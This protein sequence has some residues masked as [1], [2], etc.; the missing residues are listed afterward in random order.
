[1]KLHQIV[2]QGLVLFAFSGKNG[3][4]RMGVEV[5]LAEDV[6]EEEA[7]PLGDDLEGEEASPLDDGLE[8][9]EASPL[10]DD[11]EA[12]EASS[13][14]DDL[15][16]EEASSSDN[17]L[18]AEEALLEE[19]MVE[20]VKARGEYVP[21]EEAEDFSFQAEVS[22]MLD[23]VVNSLYQNKDVFLRELLSNAI[24]AQDKFKHMSLTDPEKYPNE[25]EMEIGIEHDDVLGTVTISDKGLGMTKDE[26][27]Q[28]LGTVAQSGTTK[29]LEAMRQS[30]DVADIA[31]I[32]QFGVGFYSAFLVAD[33]I[34]VASKSPSSD[35]QMIWES[36]NGASSFHVYP[37][38]RGNTLERGTEITLYLK[39]DALEYASQTRLVE[40][41]KRYSEFNHHH[42]WVNQKEYIGKDGDIPSH[43]RHIITNKQAMWTQDKDT[44]VDADYQRFW[45]ICKRETPGNASA[46]THF[47]AEGT[48]NFDSILFAPE[49]IPD[50]LKDGNMDSMEPGIRLY[51]QKV[52]ISEAFDLMPRYLG[53][54]RGVV[55]SNDLPLNVN[56]E[57]LQE[58]KIIKIIRKK[59]IRKALD[60]LKNFAKTEDQKFKELQEIGGS[61]A[62]VEIDENGNILESSEKPD[63]ESKYISWY[64]KFSPSLKLGVLEDEPNRQKLV[65]LLRFKTS[66]SEGAWTTLDEYLERMKDWQKDIYVHS[67]HNIEEIEQS[68]FMD[69]FFDKDVEVLYL[70]EPID[71]YSMPALGDYE[72][73]KISIISKE[74]LE[75]PDED[76]DL[77]KRREKAY[78]KQ[79]KELRTW[80][81]MIYG[82]SVLKVMISKRMGRTA[83][84]GSSSKH[85]GSAT[86]DRIQRSSAMNHRDPGAHTG[87][88]RV[89]E[90]NP[91]HPFIQ[92]FLDALRPSPDA[93]PDSNT[94]VSEEIIDAAWLLQDIAMLNGGFPVHDTHAHAERVTKF[95]QGQLKI[96][97]LEL[98]PLLNPIEEPEEAPEANFD[99]LD[100][101]NMDDF[102]F[103]DFD[104]DAF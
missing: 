15:E 102:D 13:L 34:R 51:V 92:V 29:F 53:F 31:Q 103:D 52:L 80:F 30:G 89:F 67:G 59:L 61:T 101:I 86:M 90:F 26:M 76:K 27:I 9:E 64:K 25:I 79:Y 95:L 91:R 82:D 20:F 45:N 84:I 73:A 39:E 96:D 55:D 32:G 97:S 1:M 65:K 4:D 16:A 88:Y 99:D 28:N 7:S 6:G 69:Q 50:H 66:K 22:R 57:T 71:E 38:P 2:L 98:S 75:L 44:L 46:W 49:N 17:D 5:A 70:T 33:R 104:I 62:E 54:I 60:M 43:E 40:M 21:P 24:D 94:K 83:A 11:L 10:D 19:Q 23:I 35:T 78:K 68:V 58:N 85:S 72:G 3:W 77:L 56:R 18:E 36:L 81:K 37:D 47:N 48:I 74:N 8:G 100:G 42:I 41:A 93:A 63:E 87:S 12:E 14:D